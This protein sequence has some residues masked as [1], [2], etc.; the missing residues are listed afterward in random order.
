M[1]ITPSSSIIGRIGGNWVM[2]CPLLKVERKMMKP[3]MAMN[4][5]AMNTLEARIITV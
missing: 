4:A 3:R 2:T 5:K 1:N